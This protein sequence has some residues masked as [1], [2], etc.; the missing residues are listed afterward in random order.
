MALIDITYFTNFRNIAN[1]NKDDINEALTEKIE[2][3]E[4]QF[5]TEVFGY[6]FQKLMLADQSNQ[7]YKDIID[8]VE[9]TGDDGK[10]YKWEGIKESEANYV[11]FYFYKER[12]PY[13]GGA[14]FAGAKVENATVANSQ[15]RPNYAFNRIQDALSILR[16][17][18]TVNI[19]DYPTLIFNNVE[20]VNSFGI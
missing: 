18:L 4:P 10:L 20:K 9:F 6:E 13:S 16:K 14:A 17:F 1:L 12:T 19:S 11:Y 7:I 5:L 3:L 15:D 2:K 8:G